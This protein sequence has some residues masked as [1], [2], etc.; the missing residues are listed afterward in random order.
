MSF[1]VDLVLI[2]ILEGEHTHTSK[3][4]AATPRSRSLPFSLA[5]VHSITAK[6]PILVACRAS[7]TS[8][9]TWSTEAGVDECEA[10]G[11]GTDASPYAAGVSSRSHN[12]T[13]RIEITKDV[14]ERGGLSSRG[15]RER[16]EGVGHGELLAVALVAQALASARSDEVL[17]RGFIA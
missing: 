1:V 13:P 12:H 15:K 5:S 2:Q 4:A 6:R 3:R 7:R 17:D 8:H 16:S 10:A 11:D 14:G 9:Q